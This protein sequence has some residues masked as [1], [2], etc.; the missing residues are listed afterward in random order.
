[1][2]LKGELDSIGLAELFRTLGDQRAT[3]VLTLSNPNG[4]KIIA[5]ADG[6]IA[7]I[8]DKLAERSRLGDLL[9]A[10][11]RLTDQQLLEALRIQR[12]NEPRTRLGDLLV[13]H[14][15]IRAQDITDSLKFQMEE[16]IYDL[17]TWR[18][19]NFDFD[20]ERSVDEVVAD[21]SFDNNVQRVSLNPQQLIAEATRRM[22]EWK[23]IEARL[24]SPYLCFKLTP[25]GE[26]LSSKGTQATQQILKLLK[27]GRTI[28]TTVKKSC[29]GRFN[30]CKALVK[31]LDD[32][33]IF[34]YPS[35]E[36]RMLAAE[37]RS[38]NRFSDALH[39]YRR[40]LEGLPT[41]S[42]REEL[43]E[44]IDETVDSIRRAQEAGESVEGVETVSYKEAAD[45]FK[46]RQRGKR[47]V[48]MLVLGLS[49]IA[50][51][52]YFSK[53]LI[54]PPTIAD[55]YKN[56]LT[57]ALQS[58]KEKKYTKAIAIW[59]EF[60]AKL[61]DPN[62]P[63]GK[64]VQEQIETLPLRHEEYMLTLLAP[65]EAMERSG[66]DD[67]LKPAKEGVTKLISLYG[68]SSVRKQMDALLAR[69][70]AKEEAL[71]LVERF[72]RL[73]KQL[74]V[75]RT[76]FKSKQYAVVKPVF[77]DIASV[78]TE[79]MKN[80][81]S[82]ISKEAE[83]AQKESQAALKTIAEVEERSKALLAQGEKEVLDKKAE[84][85][86]ITFS[87]AAAEWPELPSAVT[88]RKRI[89]DIKEKSTRLSNDFSRAK[90]SS[91]TGGGLEALSQFRM[92]LTTY[93]EF[94]ETL[95][96]MAIPDEIKKLE[97]D[98]TSAD[99]AIEQARTAY[100]SDKDRG[101]ELFKEVLRQFGPILA[102]RGTPVPIRVITFPPGTQVK[103]DG[104]NA[105]T[106]PLYV[107]LACGKAHQFEFTKEG[108]EPIAPPRLDR[109]T[110][111]DLDMKI[112]MKR[113]PVAEILL[114][115]G[116]RSAPRIVGDKMFALHGTSLTI[117][118]PLGQKTYFP[119][120]ENMF[121]DAA[122]NKPNAFGQ[123]HVEFVG[124]KS[125]WW[126]H[127][128]VEPIQAGQY[129]LAVRTREI[130][131]VDAVKG[132]VS[133]LGTVP[134]E[135]VGRIY[136]EPRSIQGGATF[137]AVG[138]ADGKV[139]AYELT[140][141]YEAAKPNQPKWEK[142]VDPN[143]LAPK[144]TLATGLAGRDK[145]VFMALTMSGR[146]ASYNV[147]TGNIVQSLDLKSTLAAGNSMP[148]KAEENTAA[149]VHLDGKVTAVDLL[150]FTV[151]WDLSFNRGLDEAAYA[152]SGGNGVFVINKDG[153]I[154]RYA[155]DRLNGKPNLLWTRPTGGP[156]AI[157]LHL[158][159]YLYA[160]VTTGPNSGTI[161]AIDPADGRGIWDFRTDLHPV[162]LYESG[163]H[164][165]I[166]TQEGRLIVMRID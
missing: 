106:A 55:D 121:S 154:K 117:L 140:A 12:T 83:A 63:T 66:V 151:L 162:E 10:R 146:L 39:I 159:K 143:N 96:K 31:L 80:S 2:K 112:G 135:P 4:Q 152:V 49:A 16:E 131:L 65:F 28:E 40:I 150:T 71:N 133:T 48:S 153:Q 111:D 93:S 43:Q 6:E 18:N 116:M 101:I 8:S 27:E 103:I 54:P 14:N 64:L 145:G 1:M 84:A 105:G 30:V 113:A 82:S 115:P 149:I 89:E 69:I 148:D 52:Y 9:I 127:A 134:G 166:A 73:I 44:L 160:A 124:E 136:V 78:A 164:L 20:G 47:L 34:P 91:T 36:L 41:D 25:K 85:A 58:E 74:E 92:I 76:Q 77:S 19:A 110:P 155:R 51:A 50:G 79:L 17:F 104:N 7:V 129:L 33:W 119:P 120:F 57:A 144:G 156:A 139:R 46:R 165:Y 13:K 102:Q 61:P 5:I 21:S 161:Y 94:A 99:S 72:K 109:I 158:G 95:K 100:R 138:T 60:L 37:H 23:A 88:A 141:P 163:G 128:P 32:G 125:W 107:E 59:R 123:P 126:P 142:A 3:G 98:L 35:A 67:Q 53:K 42:E 45:R 157:P 15:M 87:N 122:Q 130:L 97:S 90:T 81:D 108:Y 11:G 56:A 75:A 147:V 137:F 22:E 26:E 38:H 118:E 29:L 132:A 114:K 70:L 68:E 86:L 62:S 24:P